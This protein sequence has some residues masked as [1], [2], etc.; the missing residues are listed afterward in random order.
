[1]RTQ[2]SVELQGATEPG[3]EDVL[4]PEALDFLTHLEREFG[5]R[6]RELLE[7]RIERR[8]RLREGEALDF[9]D[10]NEEIRDSDWS[11]AP[12]PP[13][14]QQ[15]WVEITGPTDRKM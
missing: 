10:A 7:A 15:R 9:L 8:K 11:V 1:M 14:L 2:S 4:T 5:P 12:A 3:F 13:D 6:R